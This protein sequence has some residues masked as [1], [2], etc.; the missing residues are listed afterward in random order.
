MSAKS[1]MSLTTNYRPLIYIISAPS[2]SGKST[3]VNELLKLVPDLD[4]SISYTT[5]AP[6]GSEQNGKQYYFIS[7]QEFEEMIRSDDFLEHASVFG[8]YYGTARRFLREAEE[9]QHDLL[10][11]ID[12]QGAV[13]MKRKLPEAISIFVLPPDRKTLEWRLRK[14]SED[15]EDVI[16]RRLVTAS[17]EIENYDKYDYI[18]IN[19]DLE[20]SIESLQA[21]VL[22]E[23]LQ[24][25]K[26]PQSSEKKPAEM[27]NEKKQ[28]R[29]LVELADRHRLA[30]IRNRVEPILA[31]FGAPPAS[32]RP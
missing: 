2:G 21:I 12:V 30:N 3:L 25:P 13:Q 14:R 8:N 29:K 28:E 20:E 19:D 9:K 31:S 32:A 4:F 27:T 6:R 1:G 26:S 11:D 5:R 18:L 24:R 10:L 15:A 23:R 22:S 17:R 7:R 16:H